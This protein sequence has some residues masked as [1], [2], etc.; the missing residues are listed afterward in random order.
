MDMDCNFKMQNSCGETEHIFSL[1]VNC[2]SEFVEGDYFYVVAGLSYDSNVPTNIS[3]VPAFSNPKEAYKFVEKI[4]R[5]YPA[6]HDDRDYDIEF[7]PM[8]NGVEM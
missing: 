2:C 4:C 1:I 7:A 3:S 6:Y 5:K 8:W